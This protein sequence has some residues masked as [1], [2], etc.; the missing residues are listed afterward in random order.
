MRRLVA[1]LLFVGVLSFS[2]NAISEE[3]AVWSVCDSC[4]NPESV[5]YD[6]GSDILYISNVAGAGDKKDGNGWLSK[7]NSTGK[8]ISA[9]WVTGF[10]APKG[11]RLQNGTLWVS[12]IDSVVAVNTKSGKISKRIKVKGAKFLN[13]VAIA[14]D[15]TIYVSDTVGNAIYTIKNGKVSIF[16]SGKELASPNGLLFKDGKLY[17]ASWG[18]GLAKDWSTTK[19]GGIYYIEPKTKKITYITKKPLGN[20]DGLEIDQKGNFIVSDWMSGKVYRV[21]KS[22]KAKMIRK[23]PQGFADLAYVPSLNLIV[24]PEMLENKITAFEK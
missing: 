19:L 23:G 17:V 10:D 3:R 4:S 2:F 14:P 12:D 6:Q 22:G 20:L 16:M 21:N 7:L 24:V 11:M 5:Y 13:D 1:L 8:V 15:G 9:K 18:E